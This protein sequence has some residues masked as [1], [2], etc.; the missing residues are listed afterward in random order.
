MIPRLA[1]GPLE[2]PDL[3]TGAAHA[4]QSDSSMHSVWTWDGLSQGADRWIMSYLK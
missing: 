1:D 3:R 2:E 4:C